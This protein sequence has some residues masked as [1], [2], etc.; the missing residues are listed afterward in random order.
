[1]YNYYG[2]TL[3]NPNNP[4]NPIFLRLKIN[5]YDGYKYIIYYIRPEK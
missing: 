4:N 2:K 3:N 1:M 5:I